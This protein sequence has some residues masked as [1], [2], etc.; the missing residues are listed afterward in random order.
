MA[1]TIGYTA[2]NLVGQTA[3]RSL[4]NAFISV[5]DHE[6]K[7]QVWDKLTQ[8]YGEFLGIL[9]T[10]RLMGAVDR[11]PLKSNKITMFEQ[12]NIERPI[13]VGTEISTTAASTVFTLE[14]ADT[15]YDANGNG[16]LQV[17][18]TFFVPETYITKSGENKTSAQAFVKG[19]SSGEG[20]VDE[21]FNCEFFDNSVAIT[22]A[23]P[24]STEL[25]H[26]GNV[27]ARGTGQ[28]NGRQRSTLARD[29]YTS[30]LKKSQEIE[31]GV[32]GTETY[33]DD[34]DA[35]P[36]YGP[37]GQIK[38]YWYRG[39]IDME[40]QF[41]ADKDKQVFLGD[42][43]D[44]PALTETANLGGSN[45][46]RS[47]KG[48]LPHLD[49]Y[50]Q[51]YLYDTEFGMS[52]FDELDRLM[53]TQGV[54]SGD[55]VVMVGNELDRTMTN[56]SIEWTKAYSGGT[57]FTNGAF[58]NIATRFS[59]WDKGHIR[60][61][62]RNITSW[63]NPFTYGTDS[64]YANMGIFVPVSANIKTNIDGQN[65]ALNNLELMHF[66]NNGENRTNII[67]DVFG[68][69]GLGKPIL[70]QYDNGARYMLSEFMLTVASPNQ[71]GL[72]KKRS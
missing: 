32:Q 13:K 44:N 10:M 67:G 28:P 29:F 27:R 58:G 3:V 5:Y 7:P 42:Y 1:N 66:N 25:I 9:D 46:V 15:Q 6:H 48:I 41:E 71:M 62:K 20:T 30:I 51:L 64:T 36:V 38:G 21:V 60:I 70:N 65:I 47:G 14:V 12:A 34:M 4:D 17:G 54:L 43:N 50:G 40:F 19:Y 11:Y 68:M 63:S 35:F 53:E 52:Q 22:T 24:V 33:L 72:I 26:G 55:V 31:G 18:D 59:M 39:L 69:N 2:D 16:P 37:N 61:H 49:E 23:I 57:D 56:S 45:V 8:K